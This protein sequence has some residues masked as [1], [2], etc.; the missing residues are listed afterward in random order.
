MELGLFPGTESSSQ[1]YETLDSTSLLQIVDVS[2]A[3]VMQEMPEVIILPC[4]EAD[5]DSE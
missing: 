3:E 5:E 2:G 4:R 1:I